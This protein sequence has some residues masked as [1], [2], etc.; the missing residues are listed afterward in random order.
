MIA[1]QNASAHVLGH[2]HDLRRANLIFDWT[3]RSIERCGSWA[4]V[5]GA[6]R[7]WVTTQSSAVRDLDMVVTTDPQKL[8]LI[9]QQLSMTA[10]SNE[11]AILGRTSLGGHRLSIRGLSVDIWSLRSTLGIVRGWTID[12]NVF[13]SVANA[14][15]LSVD[16]LVV[17]AHGGLYE[18]GF[19]KSYNEGRMW[20]LR[21]ETVGPE[22]LARKALKIS[23][24]YRLIPDIPL[25]AL[26][27]QYAADNV[28][29]QSGE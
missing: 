20:L 19:F 26:I 25:S 14:A 2:V 22:K 24:E 13:R 27:A 6:P 3:L 15:A 17:T 1:R 8:E 7:A 21:S 4:V 10:G 18:R 9:V 23:K 5:G 29:A 12:S 28:G 11:F 16:T